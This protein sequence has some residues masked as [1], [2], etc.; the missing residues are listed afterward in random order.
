MKRG[1]HVEEVPH[2][3]YKIIFYVSYTMGH[4]CKVLS[5]IGVDLPLDEMC[6]RE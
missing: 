6:N 5:E 1:N 2:H 4:C 3:S